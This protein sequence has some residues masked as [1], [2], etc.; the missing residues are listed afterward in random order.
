MRGTVECSFNII[1]DKIEK[2]YRNIFVDSNIDELKK[3]E[4]IILL[5]SAKEDV[6]CSFLAHMNEVGYAGKLYLIGRESD[7]IYLEKF[8]RL[9]VSLFVVNNEQQYTV[10]NT[11]EYIN[12]VKADAICFLYQ[13]VISKGYE[14]IF[15]IINL[16]N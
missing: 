6:L 9:N 13:K 10:E 5:R 16:K 7:R 1:T 4:S 14:N 8:K 15:N 2:C 11:Y 12:E 3:K